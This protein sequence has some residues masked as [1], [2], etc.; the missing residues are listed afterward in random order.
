MQLAR[1]FRKFLTFVHC[2]LINVPLSGSCILRSHVSGHMWSGS[3]FPQS[4]SSLCS[5][6]GPWL[7]PSL[8]P[9]VSG[10]I[11]GVMVENR[12]GRGHGWFGPVGLR[13]PVHIWMNYNDS[14]LKLYVGGGKGAWQFFL[15]YIH[16]LI[17]LVHLVYCSLHLTCKLTSTMTQLN[18]S[19]LFHILQDY[20][21]N[22]IHG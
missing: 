18:H 3:S 9:T 2:R 1:W 17:L 8:S 20:I 10:S 4:R 13:G 7:P 14:S 22:A 11:R 16:R 19:V 6:T 21:F 5:N 12:I 15:N